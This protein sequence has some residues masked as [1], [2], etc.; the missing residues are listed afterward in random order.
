MRCVETA[1]QTQ[2]S[3]PS[4]R[5]LLARIEHLAAEQ[6]EQHRVRPKLRVQLEAAALE[7]LDDVGP[8]FQLGSE[9]ARHREAKALQA[10][11]GPPVGRERA[12]DLV[13]GLGE[14]GAAGA[15]GGRRTLLPGRAELLQ[16][17]HTEAP[18]GHAAVGLNLQPVALEP[19]HLE[20]RALDGLGGLGGD[21]EAKDGEAAAALPGGADR[22]AD[23]LPGLGEAALIGLGQGRGGEGDK[24]EGEQGGQQAWHASHRASFP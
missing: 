12:A 16:A 22:P 2:W 4:V 15:G 17:L 18:G 8:S 10:A 1:R 24:G 14:R 23:A 6:P 19:L 13:A 9:L 7:V 11:V 5:L 21:R 20:R 3:L